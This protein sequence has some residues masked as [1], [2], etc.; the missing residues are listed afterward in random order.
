[1]P[2]ARLGVALLIPP[3]LD[4]EVDGLRRAVGDP[5][6][7]RIPAHLTLVPPVNVREVKEAVA[8]LR[9]A[10]APSRPL[11]L[12]L[13]PPATFLPVNPVL[14]LSVHGE[15]DDLHALRDRVFKPPLERDLT[16]PFVPHVTLADEADPA[17]IEAALTALADYRAEV[18]FDRLTLLQ[19]GPGRIWTPLAEVAL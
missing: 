15:L 19:E 16:W 13:G 17:R 7:G 11:R 6:L 4:A 18:T 5:A 1:V 12:E 9:R 3:P 2:K 8:V 14:Y 10:A